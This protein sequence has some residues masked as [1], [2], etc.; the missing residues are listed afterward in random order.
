MGTGFQSTRPL[1]DGT[2]RHRQRRSHRHSISIHP[3]L[4][5]RDGKS[6]ASAGAEFEFQSTRPLRD[7][8][9]LDHDSLTSSAISI[10]PP[11]AGRDF[12]GRRCF[13]CR[14]I[15]IHPP[16]AGRDY[17]KPLRRCRGRNFNPPAPCGTGPIDAPADIHPMRFQ[18]TRPLRD[19]TK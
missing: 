9:D 15:S 14:I 11:L 10:H 18:S 3:P 2:Q 6:A 16:L 4:A 5:G 12:G 13:D 17:W 7:G 1:R 8:T 19:G